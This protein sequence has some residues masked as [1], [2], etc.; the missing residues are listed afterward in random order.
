MIS[1]K[2]RV[3]KNKNFFL[4]LF[5]LKFKINSIQIIILKMD[6]L[7]G[8]WKFVSSENMDQIA[9]KLNL[10][11]IK[12]KMFD[13]LKPEIQIEQLGGN[14]WRITTVTSFKTRIVEFEPNKEFE[15]E[16]LE[17][18]TVKSIVVNEN[19]K[20]IKTQCD[21]NGNVFCVIT[22]EIDQNNGHLVSTMKMDDVVAKRIFQKK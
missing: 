18:E 12:R 10:N 16:T 11:I 20:L 3:Y 8:K 6:G 21:K 5:Y 17:G 7:V 4:T 22:N 15:E 14:K 19:N 9:K 2:R 13:S 1:M